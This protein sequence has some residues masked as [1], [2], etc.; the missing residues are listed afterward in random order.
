MQRNNHQ[1][2]DETISLISLIENETLNEPF[3]MNRKEHLHK[4]ALQVIWKVISL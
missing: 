1:A 3:L 2:V 4:K